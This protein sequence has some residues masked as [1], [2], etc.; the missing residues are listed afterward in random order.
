M[1][2]TI[3]TKFFN[4]RMTAD[5]MKKLYRKL[6]LEWHPDINHAPN[7][8]EMMKLINAEFSYWYARAATEQVKEEK[9]QNNPG[10]KEYYSQHY[11]YEF[12]ENLE[13][14]IQWIYDN[15]ID[16]MP[17]LTVD[18]V[19]V[20]IWIAGITPEM[21]EE[22]AKVK[23]VG[24][25]GGYKWHDDGSKEYMWKWTPEI[26]RFKSNPNIDDIKRTYGSERKNRSDYKP[27]STPRQLGAPRKGK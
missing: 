24:F 22:R 6:A 17:G 4:G 10:K 11:S 27:A 2:A 3:S 25:Q 21:N 18:V 12:I 13:K 16:R 9:S 8:L 14:M 7:A 5:E 23:A 15:N 26:K 20:F 1:P 19:G